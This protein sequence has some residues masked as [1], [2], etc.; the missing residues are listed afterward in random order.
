M[1]DFNRHSDRE[2]EEAG[3]I[4][5]LATGQVDARIISRATGGDPEAFGEIYSVYLDRI[6]RYVFYQVKDKMMAEDITEEIFIKAWKA[7]GSYRGEGQAFSSWLYRI[8]HNQV[9]DQFRRRRWEMV[10]DVETDI[11]NTDGADPQREA[12]KSLAQAEVLGMLALL[13]PQ[14]KQVIILKFV[15]GLGNREIEEITGKSQGAIRVMQMRALDA[16]RQR[17]V[18]EK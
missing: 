5:K 4:A 16:L 11:T 6:Y 1:T 8:A 9:I 14:Q 3:G 17:A 2:G 13:P 7:L 12:E 15:E 18:Q 10:L